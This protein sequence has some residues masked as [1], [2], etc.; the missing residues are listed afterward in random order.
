MVASASA[1]PPLK[2]RHCLK[3]ERYYTCSRHPVS[4]RHWVGSYYIPRN[5]GA[6]SQIG[7][8]SS[9]RRRN[10]SDPNQ[11]STRLFPSLLHPHGHSKSIAL[12]FQN[13]FLQVAVSKTLRRWTFLH[14]R[15]AVAPKCFRYS[16]K[17][18]RDK[19]ACT[20]PANFRMADK[21]DCR[22]E[23]GS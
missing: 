5:T 7:N 21:T 9:C 19:S 10:S 1:E 22:D 18:F 12:P 11:Q 2:G 23:N 13:G 16:T 14:S 20:G 6:G 15:S 3:L 17:T 4:T 8:N